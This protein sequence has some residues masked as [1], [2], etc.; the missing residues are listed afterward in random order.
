M[1]SLPLPH[2]A[3]TA[4][5]SSLAHV[6]VGLT[7]RTPEAARPTPDGNFHLL[8]ISDVDEFGRVAVPSEERI[9]VDDPKV[10]ARCALRTGD[11]VLA[12]RGIRAKAGLIT[13]ESPVV[14]GGQFFILRIHDQRLLPG[15]LVWFLNH[16]HTQRRLFEES[17][18]SVVKAVLAPQVRGLEIPI[19]PRQI[20]S[21]ITELFELRAREKQLINQIETLKSQLIDLTLLQA[22]THF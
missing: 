3:M 4:L 8:R 11:V 17:A 19:P 22:A 12:N 9:R 6:T 5:L 16:P 2:L 14:A 15:F 21:Q 20:Q 18:V 7:L 1:H 10:I 13:T